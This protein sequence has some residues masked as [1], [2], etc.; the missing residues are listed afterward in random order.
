MYKEVVNDFRILPLTFGRGNYIWNQLVDVYN[1]WGFLN[2]G[3]VRVR[4]TGAALDTTYT[5]TATTKEDEIPEDRYNTIGDLQSVKGYMMETYSESN[6]P[7]EEAD[8]S[9][10][11]TATALGDEVVESLPSDDDDDLPF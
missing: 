1:D 7:S 6:T 3:V 11:E 4:R 2:K 9:V 10:P 8:A 5:I